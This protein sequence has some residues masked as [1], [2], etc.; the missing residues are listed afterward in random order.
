[1]CYQA[2]K[3][4]IARLHNSA[5]SVLKLSGATFLVNLSVKTKNM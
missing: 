3:K 2:M 5:S 4:L 1:M